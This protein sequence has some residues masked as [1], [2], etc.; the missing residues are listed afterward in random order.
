MK[1]KLLR[2]EM[3]MVSDNVIDILLLFF[4][5]FGSIKVELLKVIFSMKYECILPR[6]LIVFVWKELHLKVELMYCLIKSNPFSNLTNSFLTYVHCFT[7]CIYKICLALI[8]GM[9]LI[10]T[11]TSIVHLLALKVSV[12]D[13]FF[14]F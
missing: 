12:Q 5:L 4:L 8:Y 14:F 1:K 7:E 6:R 9:Y 13:I 3:N 11:C 10:K 2:T